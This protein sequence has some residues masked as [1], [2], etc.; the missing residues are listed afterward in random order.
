[1]RRG[2]GKEKGSKLAQDHDAPKAIAG[3]AKKIE[4]VYGTPFLSH[5]AMEPMNCTARVT[6]ER[7]EIWVPTQ[8]AEGSLA[9]LAEEAGL[10]LEQCEAYC[11]DL[12]G[13]FGRRGSTQDFVRYA[14]AIATA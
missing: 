7:G 13:G 12:G 4:A 9:A 1:M 6:A 3:A 14:V 2:V 5:A 8:N 10:K 11:L